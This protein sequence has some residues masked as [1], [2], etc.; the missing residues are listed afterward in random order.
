MI[1][2]RLGKTVVNRLLAPVT[3]VLAML[4]FSTATTLNVVI[5]GC[6]VN[7]YLNEYGNYVCFIVGAVSGIWMICTLCRTIERVKALDNIV[8]RPLTYLG[9]NA[10]V[11]YCVNGLIYPV[12]IPWLLSGLGL[13]TG[14]ATGRALWVVSA[15]VVNLV[16]C[17]IVASIINR[18][19]PELLGRK[20]N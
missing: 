11:I 19:V 20:R 10:L 6:G 7:A 3:L 15:L 18:F 1:M 5:F 17:L 12:V 4:V 9:R 14:T 13:D 8:R 16:I 2:K